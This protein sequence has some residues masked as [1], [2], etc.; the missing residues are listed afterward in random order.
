M[1]NKIK[2]TLEQR[3]L[4][5]IFE[6]GLVVEMDFSDWDICIRLVV[7]A[8]HAPRSGGRTPMYLVE[9]HDPKFLTWLAPPKPA[10][11]RMGGWRTN[12][13]KVETSIEGPSKFT[14]DSYENKALLE[15]VAVR[16][17]AAE[18][19]QAAVDRAFPGWSKA[20][21]PLRPSFITMLARTVL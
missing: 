9:F 3:L 8:D 5:I 7:I 15:I 2:E 21:R 20:H 12:G 18:I 17:T 10:K 16:V 19:D 4:R 14:I 11:M 13:W 1:P 6:D